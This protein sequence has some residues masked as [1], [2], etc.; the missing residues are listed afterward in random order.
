MKPELDIKPLR[1]PAGRLH[2]IGGGKGLQIT[3]VGGSVWITQTGD[4]RDV[5][6]TR[7][8]SFILECKGLAVVYALTDAAI[9]VGPAG[10]ITAAAFLPPAEWGH[11]P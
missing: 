4:R 9:V 6:L 7:G 3:A 11:T 2:R 10:H 5:V 8:R 1:L